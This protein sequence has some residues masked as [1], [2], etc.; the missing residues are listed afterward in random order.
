MKYKKTLI[1]LVAICVI[2]IVTHQVIKYNHNDDYKHKQHL[3]VAESIWGVKYPQLGA[4]ESSTISVPIAVATDSKRAKLIGVITNQYGIRDDILQYILN[5]VPASNKQGIEAAIHLAQNEYDIYYGSD[6]PEKIRYSANMMGH[7]IRCMNVFFEEQDHTS[8]NI[9]K[10]YRNTPAR[11]KRMHD[12]EG[13][14]L[15]GHVY[16]DNV[17]EMAN[18]NFSDS[19]QYCKSGGVYWK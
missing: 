12:I 5:N 15:G 2:L 6:D 19:E 1:T 17:G 7:I 14:I 16:D 18:I 9:A 8:R 11:E 10:L 4:I 3:A 13:N